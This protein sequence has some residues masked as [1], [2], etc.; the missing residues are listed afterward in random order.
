MG[1][2]EKEGVMRGRGSYWT[3]CDTS[4]AL[5]SSSPSLPPLSSK[6][7]LLCYSSQEGLVYT[8]KLNHCAVPEHQNNA[9]LY[10]TKSCHAVVQ[11]THPQVQHASGRACLMLRLSQ[12]YWD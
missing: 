9:M 8:D 12:C 3:G 11:A 7:T 5:S 6:N 2:V 1:L 4:P 10:L